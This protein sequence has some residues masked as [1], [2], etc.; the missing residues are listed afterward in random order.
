[1]EEWLSKIQDAFNAKDEEL[2]SA[3]KLVTDVKAENKRLSLQ[4]RN[5]ENQIALLQGKLKKIETTFKTI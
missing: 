2:A 3:Q 1:M 5:A 4:I